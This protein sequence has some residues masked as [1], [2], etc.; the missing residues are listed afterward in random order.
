M[1]K[2]CI[3]SLNSKGAASIFLVMAVLAAVLAIVLGSS[4]VVSTEIKSN[5]D[6][7]ES[8]AAY[9]AAESGMERA[10]YEKANLNRVPRGNRCI[11]S[12]CPG[13]ATGVVCAG[14]WTCT[15]SVLTAVS[16]YC[17]EVILKPLG[18]PCVVDDIASVKS[19]GENKTTRR[20]IEISF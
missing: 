18:D 5:L 6:S 1:T 20:S 19:I 10:M 8:V 9:Y 17:I 15:A 2:N 4:M 13:G 3:I 16:P 7:G 12:N 11:V 14:S